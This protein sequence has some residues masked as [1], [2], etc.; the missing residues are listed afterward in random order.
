MTLQKLENIELFINEK[1][2][3]IEK[4]QYQGYCNI[5]YKVTTS[6]S[7][8]LVRVFKNDESV[9]ISREFEYKIQKKASLLGISS[10]PLYLD[11][12]K[13]FMITNFLNG[14]HKKE[15]NKIDI[16]KLTKTIKK[17]HNIKY[18]NNPYNLKK[19]F[20]NYKKVLKDE[21]SKRLI[22]ESISELNKIKKYKAIYV[23]T[24]HDLNPKNIIFIKDKI[25]FIDWEYCGVN[26][27][28]FDLASVCVEFNLDKKDYD[29]VL[30]QYFKRVKKEHKIQLISYIKIYKNICN[31]WFKVF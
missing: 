5:N 6:K 27:T 8:Y 18:Y 2:Q 24:H 4:L 23:T 11:E 9:N 19:D 13:R 29:I 12:E 21:K 15:L 14:S 20:I 1:L 16:R 31:L 26:S 25:K 17:L 7:S 10:K 30:K 28:F 3:S 22:R